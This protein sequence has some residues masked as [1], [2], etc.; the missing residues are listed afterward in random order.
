MTLTSPSMDNS[1]AELLPSG[2][3][4]LN[5]RMTESLLASLS[6][7]ERAAILSVPAA[8][9]PED[10]RMFARWGGAPCAETGS[11]PRCRPQDWR[12]RVGHPWSSFRCC[13]ARR[14]RRAGQRSSS[15]PWPGVGVG[16]EVRTSWVTDPG[17]LG[18]WCSGSIRWS[19][20]TSRQDSLSCSGT[21]A[22]SPP[23]PPPRGVGAAPRAVLTPVPGP[24]RLLHYFRGRR[25]LEEIMY[26]ENTRR[27]QLLA[28]VDKFRSVLVVTAHE[29]PVIAVFQA[30]LT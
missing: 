15:D 20:A 14:P 21:K 19:G 3:S 17:A 12:L 4:P 27:S 13:L 28:L 22:G 6:E 18:T 5:R 10:L 23:P 2:D 24:G 26:N 29:D 1:S 9:N 8:Q 30:L 7:H 16:R 25:H 11:G